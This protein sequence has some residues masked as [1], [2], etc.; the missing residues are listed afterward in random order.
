MKYKQSRSKS[1]LRMPLKFLI[2]SKEEKAGA[3]ARGLVF[4]K[5][6]GRCVGSAGLALA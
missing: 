1:R 2:P 4:A 3:G 6:A 5:S